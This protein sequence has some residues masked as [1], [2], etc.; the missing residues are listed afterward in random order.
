LQATSQLSARASIAIIVTVT[1]A[2]QA[3]ANFSSRAS[4]AAYVS[5]SRLLKAQFQS[6]ASMAATGVGPV[7]DC[8]C[9]PWQI[10][11][12]PPCAWT[13]NTVQCSTGGGSGEADLPFTLPMFRLY[14]L[15]TLGSGTGGGGYHQQGETTC[16]ISNVQ[17]LA[18][19]TTRDATLVNAFGKRG[20]Q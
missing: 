11:P 10:D 14:V 5:T 15:G 17:T 13:I 4:S 8:E 3:V 18:N 1:P 7:P 6:R 16:T 20:C 9:P 19:T 12:A 2:K